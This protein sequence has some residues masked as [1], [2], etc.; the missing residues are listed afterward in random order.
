MKLRRNKPKLD[1][2][3]VH[4]CVNL[5]IELDDAM[6]LHRRAL[7]ELAGGGLSAATR[8]QLL[9]QTRQASV[10]ARAGVGMTEGLATM[11]DYLQPFPA[12]RALQRV[13]LGMVALLQQPPDV[14]A[15]LTAQELDRDLID[16]ELGEWL[17]FNLEYAHE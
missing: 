1:P 13:A 10:M 5:A 14:P 3:H 8:Q 12:M 15:A 7:D 6:K 4:F 11:P 2:V 16:D 17:G 9:L